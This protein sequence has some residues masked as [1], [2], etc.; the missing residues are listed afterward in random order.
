MPPPAAANSAVTGNLSKEICKFDKKVADKERKEQIEQINAMMKQNPETIPKV[1]NLLSSGALSSTH[2]SGGKFPK[3]AIRYSDLSAKWINSW[4]ASLQVPGLDAVVLAQ[5]MAQ[6][7]QAPRKLLCFACDVQDSD[8]LCTKVKAEWC[9]VMTKRHADL[10]SRLAELAPKI[11]QDFQIAWDNV[12][13]Y[14]VDRKTSVITTVRGSES[15]LPASIKIDDEWVLDFNWCDQRAV[16]QHPDTGIIFKLLS[17]FT[18]ASS[19]KKSPV[20]DGPPAAE[21]KCSEKEAAPSQ[22]EKPAVEANGGLEEATPE[23]S[24]PKKRKVLGAV[25]ARPCNVAVQ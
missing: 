14:R 22:P 18:P 24:N 12:G 4:L 23:K 17:L 20:K 5:V 25:S 3:S 10:G 9:E 16:L 11:G 19:P 1:L 13:V 8:K 21:E 15:K 2:T 7:P 6:D